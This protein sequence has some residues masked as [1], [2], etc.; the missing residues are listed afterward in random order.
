MAIAVSDCERLSAQFCLTISHVEAAFKAIFAHQQNPLQPEDFS[1][2]EITR[3]IRRGEQRRDLNHLATSLLP[4]LGI[5][6]E[7]VTYYASFVGDYSVS[8]L[9]RFEEATAHVYLLCFVYH[10]SQRLH[11]TV[12]SSLIHHVRRD[13]E[14]AKTVAKERVYASRSE[15]NEALDRA[16]QVLRLFTDDG[17]PQQT[18]FHAVRA[19]ACSMLERDKIDF[20]ADHITTKVKCDAT[21]FQWEHMDELAHQFQ[22]HLR[23]L[24]L[25]VDGTASAGHT[26]LS[27][28]VAF[29]KDAL[30]QGR[31]LSQ[32]PPS[33]S[34]LSFIPDTAKR[35]LS[36]QG[37]HN[38]RHVLPDRSEFLVSRLLRNAFEAGDVFCRESVRFRSCED[39]LSDDDRWQDKENL[40]A[41]TDL[42][43]LKQPIREHLAALETQLEDRLIQ[44]NQR[45]ASG[46]NV[47][48][49]IQ[50]RGSQTRWTL[51]YPQSA[52]LLNHPCFE[53]LQQV[54]LR[55]VLPCVHRHCRFLEAFDHV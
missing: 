45:I 11:D 44:V 2:S 41:N 24:L 4:D 7:S 38:Q 14:A 9:T 54:D 23:P 1:A 22:R 31:S 5:S 20:V 28:A 15:G 34:P 50:K 53:A 21:A 32:Y 16:G 47:H 18:P 55:S 10:R 13:P 3:E 43:L 36:A 6:H 52:A 29:L 26:A 46:E 27:E 35:S 51:Q 8:K 48:F 39:D 33:A 17:L 42:P 12:L 37:V 25:A 19:K 40:M 49:A 30:Q